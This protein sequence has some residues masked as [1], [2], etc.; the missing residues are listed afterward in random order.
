M[1]QYKHWM[2]MN[3]LIIKYYIVILFFCG[4]YLF[5]RLVHKH[6]YINS[7]ACC[8]RKKKLNNIFFLQNIHIT[9][10]IKCGLVKGERSESITGER[11]SVD[12]L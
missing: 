5:I 6:V 1:L 7:V 3:M 11:M 9:V 10:A 2:F 8:N 12:L 4:Q